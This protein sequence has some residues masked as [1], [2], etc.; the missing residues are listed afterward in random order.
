MNKRVGEK[1]RILPYQKVQLKEWHKLMVK[2]K[3]CFRFG[4]H[5]QQLVRLVQ[6][7]S[8][9]HLEK[10]LLQNRINSKNVHEFNCQK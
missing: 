10:G 1:K 4:Y 2:N 8:R 3:D 5:L 6:R 9:W 7:Q